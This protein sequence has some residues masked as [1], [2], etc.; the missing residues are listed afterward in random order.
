[1]KN[2]KKYLVETL[3]MNDTDAD[4]FLSGFE[5]AEYNKGDYLL[6]EG[7]KCNIVRV[8]LRG[9]ARGF[10]VVDGKEITTNFYFE[11]D[12]TYD[13]MRYLLQQAAEINIL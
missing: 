8:I 6:E 10:V 4:L 11:N 1:M 9:C 7:K 13:Y 3:A 12:H 5:L 2:Y